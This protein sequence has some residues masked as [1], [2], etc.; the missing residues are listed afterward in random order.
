M[1]QVQHCVLRA[2]SPSAIRIASAAAC[3]ALQ[4]RQLLR[5]CWQRGYPKA[6]AHAREHA[7]ATS[8]PWGHQIS[9]ICSSCRR[10]GS[11]LQQVWLVA[12]KHKVSHTSA[13]LCCSIPGSGCSVAAFQ[14]QMS[15]QPVK[16]VSAAE[17]LRANCNMG[18][19]TV[20]TEHLGAGY[21]CS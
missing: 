6:A 3:S 15:M 19:S 2:V 7:G 20:A 18:A 9:Q 13:Q 12:P 14:P 16:T 10:C 11:Q 17:D 8:S 5:A 1:L 4:S 21:R